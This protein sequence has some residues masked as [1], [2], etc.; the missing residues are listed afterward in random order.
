MHKTNYWEFGVRSNIKG[1]IWKNWHFNNSFPS[2]NISLLWVI[3]GFPPRFTQAAPGNVYK[4]SATKWGWVRYWVLGVTV[5][6]YRA[7]GAL[8]REEAPGVFIQPK[9]NEWW[10]WNK[11]S[12]SQ[13][14]YLSPLLEEY[15]QYC[16][17]KTWKQKQMKKKRPM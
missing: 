9:C 16:S 4:E 2:I 15:K 14:T 8:A 10:S 7:L 17:I 3:T 5:L 11:N 1:Q 13:K 6:R 12:Q